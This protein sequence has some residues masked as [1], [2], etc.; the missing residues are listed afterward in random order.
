MKKTIITITSIVACAFASFAADAAC[1]NACCASKPAK[2]INTLADE[3]VCANLLE[4]FSASVSVGYESEY[5]FRGLKIQGAS[6]NPEVDFAYDL[7]S[8]FAVYAGV[9]GNMPVK[10]DTENEMD[11]YTGITYDFQNFTFDLG[12]LAYLYNED[13]ENSHEIKFAVSYDTVDLLGEFNVSPTVAFYHDFSLD[14]YTLEA[15]LT[16]SAPVTKWIADRNWGTIDLAAVYGWNSVKSLSAGRDGYTYI[17]LSA[18][19][20]VA[21]ND[22]CKFSVGVRYAYAHDR[23]AWYRDC[24][25]TVWFGTSMTVGF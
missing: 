9:W 14:S 3:E 16:Y 6:I 25:E 1:T 7:G 15:G 5:V 24:D 10:S 22:Y 13:T 12:Y 20:V 11:I 18:D 2:Q 23:P 17:A 21:L 4:R 19:A 8:G